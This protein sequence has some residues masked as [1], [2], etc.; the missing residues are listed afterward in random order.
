[1]VSQIS[2][3]NLDENEACYLELAPKPTVLR[4]QSISIAEKRR[5]CTEAYEP[6]NFGIR[7]IAR[8][9]KVQPS[10]IRRWN[11]R[12]NEGTFSVF[13]DAD[14]GLK[15]RKKK[16]CE[17]SKFFRLPGA[18]RK[19]S[20]SPALIA[21]LKVFLDEKRLNNMSV[22]VRMLMLEARRVDPVSCRLHPLTFRSR[23][24]RLCLCL[25]GITWRKGTSKAQVT[26]SCSRL[27]ADFKSMVEE[28]IAMYNI[29]LQNIYNADQTNVYYSMEGRY[30]LE[31][32]GTKTITVRG[33][34][35]SS[36]S[37][38][39]LGCGLDGTKIPPY[40]VYKGTS[41]GRIATEF[42]NSVESGYP[43][44]VVLAVQENAWFDEAIMLDWIENCW[45]KHIATKNDEIYYLF[46]DSFS[47][48]QT[49]TIKEA[50]TRCNTEVEYVPEGYTAALQVMDVGVN[51]P[52]KGFIRNEFDDWL[53]ATFEEGKASRPSRQ[54][55][56]G[57]I[58]RAFDQVST[59]TIKN[60]WRKA[61]SL[62]LVGDDVDDDDDV[63]EEEDEDDEEEEVN[64][65]L[66]L[67]PY[68]VREV[69]GEVVQENDTTTI[70]IDEREQ[71]D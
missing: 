37:T 47:V 45:K 66:I 14:D 64:N 35:T 20:F 43:E 12:F 70:I 53:I 17:S 33:A 30:T 39:M 44:G 26:R 7:A 5:I 13:D 24:R 50:F 51:K 8:K 71:Q 52:F 23:I 22:D 18:G 3:G 21:H 2:T 19:H 6:G 29:P 68:D 36:R 58:K 38:V 10:Q 25:W 31:R 59:T 1:M 60:S 9:Y 15:K 55:V 49:T 28:K 41:N 34:A 48:H 69:D 11:R 61:T 56:T 62:T 57:W 32:R 42:T 40:V 63:D 67:S 27:I 65:Y 54:V 4:R 16:R 46:L